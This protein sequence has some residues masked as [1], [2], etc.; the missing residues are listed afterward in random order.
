MERRKLPFKS[1]FDE[2]E[3]NSQFPH[4]FAWS[5]NKSLF[6]TDN[7]LFDDEDGLIIKKSSSQFSTNHYVLTLDALIKY[8]V[9]LVFIIAEIR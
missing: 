9:F 4:I 7:I 6:D 5:R 3:E 8:K 1:I 2:I